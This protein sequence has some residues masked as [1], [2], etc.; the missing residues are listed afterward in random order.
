MKFPTGMQLSVKALESVRSAIVVAD[1]TD[2]E[3][4][5]VYMNSAFQTLTGY[6][7]DEVFGRNCRFLQGSDRDQPSR[8]MIH[9]ALLNERPVRAVLR[10]YRKDG[11][12]FYNQLF[13]DSLF[14]PD[15][16]AT[17]FV[18]C[19]NATSDPNAA[20]VHQ[21]ASSRWERLT[22]RERE[23]FPMLANGYHSKLI[24]HELGISSR[25]VEKH[26]ISIMKKFDVS[27]FT[28]VVRYAIALG[29]PLKEA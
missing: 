26:R 20:K 24:A 28:L 4:P 25:T 27:D 10:N 9:D 11:S 13:I 22:E 29:I 2:P 7:P 21:Y 8:A 3:Q 19:Q 5:I 12:L 17:H 14:G 18:A 1:A 15:G 16:V 6:G 23:V